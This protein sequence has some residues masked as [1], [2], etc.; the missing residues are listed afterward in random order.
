MLVYLVIPDGLQALLFQWN[1]LEIKQSQSQQ[2]ASKISVSE[3]TAAS[4]GLIQDKAD[5]V[6]FTRSL[7]GSSAIFAARPRSRLY[8]CSYVYARA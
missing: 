8:W 3:T 2:S 5:D 6:A 1:P 7:K 4:N